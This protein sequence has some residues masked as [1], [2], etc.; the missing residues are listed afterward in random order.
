LELVLERILME[1]DIWMHGM[2][3]EDLPYLLNNRDVP[4][5]EREFEELVI[6]E[7]GEMVLE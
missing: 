1:N 2:V 3:V 7:A 6:S 5:A 4:V